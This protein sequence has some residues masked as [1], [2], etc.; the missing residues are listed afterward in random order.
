MLYH[1]IMKTYKHL[2]TH[3]FNAITFPFNS[4]LLASIKVRQKK[5][6]KS[7]MLV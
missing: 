1:S 3:A 7:P 6:K 2:K 5:K 4:I